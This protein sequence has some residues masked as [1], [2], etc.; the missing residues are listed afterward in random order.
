[1][2]EPGKVAVIYDANG[3]GTGEV[4]VDNNIYVEGST[5]QV[6]DNTGGLARQGY[7]FGGWMVDNIIFQPGDSF[8]IGNGDITLSAVW[9]PVYRVI[10]DANANLFSGSP[11]S[12]PVEYPSGAQVT[13]KGNSGNLSAPG[14]FGLEYWTTEPDGSGQKLYLGSTFTMGDSDITLYAKYSTNFPLIDLTSYR[15]TYYANGATSGFAPG[16]VIQ[17]S[18]ITISGNTGNLMKEGYVF[19]GW[20]T[21]AD[22][23]GTTYK[24]GDIDYSL[25]DLVLY[26]QWAPVYIVSYITGTDDVPA[27][28]EQYPQG[29]KL[30]LMDYSEVSTVFST[31]I[32]LGWNTRADGSGDT[33]MPGDVITVDSDLTLYPIWETNP[34]GYVV[35][36]NGNGNTDGLLPHKCVIAA[37]ERITIPSPENLAKGGYVFAG[38]FTDDG[39]DYSVGESVQINS[40]V[41]FYARWIKAYRV[42]YD[43]NGNA[44]TVPMDNT[45]YSPGAQVTVQSC[46]G[47]NNFE[48]WNTRPDGRGIS[49]KPGDTFNIY[50]DVTLYAI[51]GGIIIID[52]GIPIIL[53]LPLS[54]NGNTAEWGSPPEPETFYTP[55]TTIEIKGNT[56][57]F[58]KNG[59]VFSGWNTRPDGS[60]ITFKPGDTLIMP[61]NPVVLFAIWSVPSSETVSIRFAEIS[62]ELGNVYYPVFYDELGIYDLIPKGT[63]IDIMDS[64]SL[65]RKGYTFAGWYETESGNTYRPEEKITVNRKFRFQ[66]VWNAGATYYRLYYSIGFNTN[67]SGI[68]T[69]SNWYEA[70]DQATLS[71]SIPTC[72]GKGFLGWSTNPYSSAPNYF[73]GQKI[74]FGK[75][76]IILYPVFSD[77]T[78]YT[79]TYYGNGNGGGEALLEI[80][81]LSGQQ[82]VVQSQNT[83][84]KDG[85]YF[86][87]W[88]TQPDGSGTAYQPGDKITIGSESIKLY[89]IWNT[90]PPDIEIEE[91]YTVTYVSYG[92]TGGN[93]PQDGN[94]YVAGARVTLKDSG[95]LYK[96]GHVFY[97]WLVNNNIYSPGDTFAINDSDVT[98]YAIWA[99]GVSEDTFTTVFFS[100]NGNTGGT[101]PDS[102]T[103]TVGSSVVLPDNTGNLT[104]TGYAFGGWTDNVNIYKPGQAY[105]T[106]TPKETTLY[107]VWLPVKTMSYYG[108]MNTGGSVP[109]DSA[110]YAMGE[111]I[112]ILD[113]V[114][115]L[116]RSNYLFAGWFIRD[117]VYQPGETF[118]MPADDVVASAV[119]APVKESAEIPEEP[120]VNTAPN[121]K[122][123]VPEA[124]T[125]ETVVGEVYRIDLADIFEDKDGDPLTYYV[126]INNGDFE[127]ANALYEY[128]VNTAGS[129]TLLFKANDGKADS[130][131]YTVCLT[132]N[133]VPETNNVPC[134]KDRV[135]ATTEDAVT[136]GDTYSVDLSDIFEG[137][138]NDELTYY[139]SVNGDPY[140]LADS[141]YE[142]TATST[143]SITLIF[144]ANDGNA[145]SEDTYK[146]ILIVENIPDEEETPGSGEDSGGEDDS[147]NV[148]PGSGS[149]EGSSGS[150][151]ES[152]DNTSKEES[153]ST[154][155]DNEIITSGNT[156]TIVPAVT[157]EDNYGKKVTVE[158]RKDQ[159]N[160]AIAAAVE[161]AE[162]SGSAG[163]V[164]VKVESPED[165]VA[166]EVSIPKDVVETANESTLEALVISTSVAEIA[167]DK[168]TLNTINQEAEEDVRIT[169]SKVDTEELSE[170]IRQVVG[171]RPVY[172]F[173]VISG[174]KV[175][176]RFGG[177]VTVSVPYSPKPDEDINAIV[178]YYI[179][180]EGELEIVRDC[181]YD[182]TTGTVRFTTDHFSKYAVGYNKLSFNDVP[183]SAWYSK[184]VTFIAARGIT[185]GTGNGNFSPEAKLTRGQ[186]LV[187]LMRAYGIDPDENTGDN[188]ADA[189]NTYYTGYL[190]AAK[191]LGISAGIGNNMFGPDREITRQEVFAMLYNILK[192]TGK[193]PET[194]ESNTMSMFKDTGEISSWALDATKYLVNAGI[195]NGSNG[196]LLP[197]ETAARAQ[198][199][200]VLYSLFVK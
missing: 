112:T 43:S 134:R 19:T 172:E 92:H 139:V 42:K 118:I 190:A 78:V 157:T 163:R 187:M 125:V 113:N 79:V 131:T 36:F 31:G 150:P 86:D 182:S 147:G 30:K 21:K 169:A 73:P 170:E 28:S 4:P 6:L 107:A 196:R 65:Y 168:D 51:L 93:V 117:R 88:N 179:N 57:G 68:P 83:L 141:L 153:A 98:V 122:A 33:Y 114:N 29:S 186:F 197:K 136:V 121:R 140:I 124:T 110:Q 156:I 8:I 146:V 3:A 9:I 126:S 61:D 195:I 40:D 74:T 178:I 58:H 173:S 56:G 99:S 193:L 55:G 128:S 11:P 175:I 166:V 184:A 180:A 45:D 16:K 82:A 24:P 145:D 62:D 25:G 70:G 189:G 95:T 198:M 18:P 188:F 164:S 100:G 10:Y 72:P 67:V 50:S 20:N 77:Q 105:Y 91:T 34:E 152:R 81:Y 15:V 59:Y 102:V 162:Q 44:A 106:K 32:F 154:E 133:E 103:C 46:P 41:T 116:S 80:R 143:G 115:N 96:E 191:R 108:N 27:K 200:Q 199:A 75:A 127:I 132:V 119:W 130:D 85:Y 71:K 37:G 87:G 69:D 185:N 165:S 171:D 17:Y 109:A 13:V 158:I 63:K 90:L 48:C 1:M 5:V 142:Y 183:E 155:T 7:K 94:K 14:T 52:P 97:G 60:G 149:D 53:L 159:V 160:S 138:D 64:G 23:T 137:G 39:H 161:N 38:W 177:Y 76:D 22:G 84:T 174:D 151:S 176:S 111:S 135:P 120:A 104:R 47:L 12:D 49:Y 148:T 144:K 101:V 192:V 54:Y 26:A 89:A 194:S 129:T 167:F 181:V 123:G 2:T 35:S 66:S